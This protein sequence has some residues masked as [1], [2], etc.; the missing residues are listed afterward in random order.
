MD[1]ESEIES[2]SR[3]I[4]AVDSAIRHAEDPF[5]RSACGKACKAFVES[6]SEER[7]RLVA[8]MNEAVR[9]ISQAAELCA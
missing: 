4:D 9:E 3:R 8:E 7:K 5:V 2:L 6:L 1:F